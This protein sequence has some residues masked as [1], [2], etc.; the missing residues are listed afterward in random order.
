MKKKLT[1]LT[2]AEFRKWAIHYLGCC[3]SR[4]DEHFNPTGEYVETGTSVMFSQYDNRRGLRLIRF[5][6]Q[7]CTIKMRILHD[8][9][10]RLLDIEEQAIAN[11]GI[12]EVEVPEVSQEEE[13]RAARVNRCLPIER[14]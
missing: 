6:I 4:I 13:R 9:L 5:L 3:N 2:T 11:N 14:S 10:S 12:I 8:I 7:S 1:E